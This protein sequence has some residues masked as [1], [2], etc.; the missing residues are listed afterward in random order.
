MIPSVRLTVPPVA[1]TIHLFFLFGK[2]LKNG[3][4]RTEVI[5]YRHHHVFSKILTTTGRNILWV[6]LVDQ[7]IMDRN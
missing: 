3:D 6:G 1:I 2:I 4:R 7:Q 5:A